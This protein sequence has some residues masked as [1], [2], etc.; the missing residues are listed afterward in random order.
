MKKTHLKSKHLGWDSQGT[1]TSLRKAKAKAKGKQDAGSKTRSATS[2]PS[3]VQVPR[4]CHLEPF[5]GRTQVLWT[6]RPR[7]PAMSSSAGKQRSARASRC[8]GMLGD[9]PGQA[10]VV[11]LKRQRKKL[12]KKKNKDDKK[13]LTDEIKA[14]TSCLAFL[15]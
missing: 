2:S 3:Q 13:V 14:L 7:R 6:W 11:D 8:G 4:D 9:R 5:G 1:E 12:P 15:E 10:K